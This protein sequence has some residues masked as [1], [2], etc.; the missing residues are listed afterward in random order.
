MRACLGTLF[1]SL[2]YPHNA[3]AYTH[4]SLAAIDD[5]VNVNSYSLPMR[6]LAVVAALIV[7]GHVPAVCIGDG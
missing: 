7:H 2:K 1:E 4:T 3:H 5:I 6:M